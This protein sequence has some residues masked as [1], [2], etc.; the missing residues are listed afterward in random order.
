[1]VLP[2][3][4]KFNTIGVN[5][6][7]ELFSPDYLLVVDPPVAFSDHRRETIEQTNS[8]YFVTCREAWNRPEII[9]CNIGSRGVDELQYKGRNNF[10]NK[11][12]TSP[13]VAVCLAFCLGAKR[14]GLLGVDFT[15]N[16]Y[17]NNDG[18]H[19]LYNRLAE[20]DKDFSRLRD[21]LARLG[22]ELVNLSPSSLLKSLKKQDIRTWARNS[23]TKK[24]RVSSN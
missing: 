6:I 23:K 18:K 22:C 1:M 14:I 10:L 7:G 3:I 17:N 9:E 11:S 24:R 2:F 5:D 21:E 12:I 4:D 8:K 15:D 20:I 16:H 13:Y 19:N